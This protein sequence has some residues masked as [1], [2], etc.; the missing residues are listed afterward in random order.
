[1]DDVRLKR[2]AVSSETLLEPTVLTGCGENTLPT[3]YLLVAGHASSRQILAPSGFP[4]SLSI[5]SSRVHVALLHIL[6]IKPAGYLTAHD[7]LT[8]SE[9]TL[10]KDGGIALPYLAPAPS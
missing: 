5:F 8:H 1:M 2:T 9:D 7:W 4:F 3:L 6:T 10:L